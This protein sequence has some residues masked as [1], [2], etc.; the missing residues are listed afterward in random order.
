MRRAVQAN[1]GKQVA[2][3]HKLSRL[4]LC[5]P[6]IPSFPFSSTLSGGGRWPKPVSRSLHQ[7]RVMLAPAYASQCRNVR[8][9]CDLQNWTVPLFRKCCS[10]M[11]YEFPQHQ[12]RPTDHLPSGFHILPGLPETCLPPPAPAPYVRLVSTR[13]QR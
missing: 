9:S 4:L 7:R 8:G 11:G 1:S 3:D 12:R 5:L 2:A 13:A 10:R 6:S